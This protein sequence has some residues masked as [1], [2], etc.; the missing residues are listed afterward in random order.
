MDVVDSD[1]S[2][3]KGVVSDVGLER[4]EEH[5]RS[6]N[7]KI[8]VV[9]RAGKALNFDDGERVMRQLRK[10]LLGKEV[11]I[12]AT[13]IRCPICGKGFNNEHGMKQH[14]RLAHKDE[15]KPSKK[16]KTTT[17][18]TEKKKE[19]KKRGSGEAGSPGF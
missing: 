5:F 15:K 1:Q 16:A 17:K 2:R 13:T 7:V 19:R 14:V 4:N 9:V 8:G 10:E 12:T 11:E 3:I 6:F 18:A